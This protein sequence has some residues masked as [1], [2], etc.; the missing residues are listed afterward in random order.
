LSGTDVGAPFT[1]A[2]MPYASWTGRLRLESPQAQISFN[3]EVRFTVGFDGTDGTII[4]DAIALGGGRQTTNNI[5][6]NGQFGA[7]GVIFGTTTADLGTGSANVSATLSGL[8]GVDGAVAV[9]AGNDA[10]TD[11]SYAGGF[12]ARPT[13]TAN[14]NGWLDSF[15]TE[16]PAEGQPTAGKDSQFLQ[17]NEAGDG[18]NFGNV[19]VAN[20]GAITEFRTLKMD[21]ND[22]NGVSFF[23]GSRGVGGSFT[24]RFF[25]GMLSGTNMGEPL[26]PHT[27]GNPMAT[28]KGKIQWLGFLGGVGFAGNSSDARDMDLN[29]NYSLRTIEAFVNMDAVGVRVEEDNRHLLLEAGYNERGQFINGTVKYGI[30]ENAGGEADKT[31]TRVAGPVNIHD[32]RQ[33]DRLLD[34]RLTGIIGQDGAVGVFIND[35]VSGDYGFAGG[36]WVV[37]PQ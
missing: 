14:Y 31:A 11:G 28:W 17:S 3:E 25:A 9:F 19:T 24:A 2:N 6:I 5:T 30:F 26:A 16:L 35:Q 12:V 18:L 8:I 1:N 4:T 27:D 37:P 10:T 29:V 13:F 34:G 7:D 32:G 15:D 36:F 21:G 33:Y 20:S 22:K 23:R